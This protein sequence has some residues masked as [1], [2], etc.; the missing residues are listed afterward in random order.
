[1]SNLGRGLRRAQ[2]IK[3]IFARLRSPGGLKEFGGLRKT[4]TRYKALKHRP[5]KMIH[6]RSMKPP[7]SFQDQSVHIWYTEPK[8]GTTGLLR[9]HE[10]SRS[11]IKNRI[12]SI[13]K[14]FRPVR[15]TAS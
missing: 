1:M 2:Q 10:Y 8:S 6:E 15:R 13:R 11:E 3:A 4:I 7:L 12:T 9:K 5:G 14:K